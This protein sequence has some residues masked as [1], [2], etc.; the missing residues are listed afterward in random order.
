[1]GLATR[2]SRIDAFER[3]LL[4]RQVPPDDELDQYQQA[5]RD[6]QEVDQADD[7]MTK[8]VS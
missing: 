8:S 5:Q 4:V 3:R 6:R 2:L 1:L 7:A